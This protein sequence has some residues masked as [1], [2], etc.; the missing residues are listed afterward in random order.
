[1]LDFVRRNKFIL[2]VILGIISFSLI[3]PSL[4]TLIDSL[5]NASGD[6]KTYLLI[7]ITEYACFMLTAVVFIIQ[8]SKKYLDKTLISC[9]IILYYASDTAELL[10]NF[11][12]YDSYSSVFYIVLNVVIIIVS[13]MALTNAKYFFTA[14]II[15]LIDCAFSLVQTFNGSA[16]GFASLMLSLMI[17]AAIYFYSSSSNYGDEYYN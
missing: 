4:I 8:G 16:V 3:V 10:Y 15:L 1:M 6:Y 17:I 11:I 14:A 12:K 13:I 2:F 9:G 7:R 5:D